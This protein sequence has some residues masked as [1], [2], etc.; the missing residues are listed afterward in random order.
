MEKPLLHT[1]TSTP[2]STTTTL[3]TAAP[4]NSTNATI[5]RPPGHVVV[6]SGGGGPV[7]KPAP[8][9]R[10][11]AKPSLFQPSRPFHSPWNF[12]PQFPR[13]MNRAVQQPAAAIAAHAEVLQQAV[14]PILV[15]VCYHV[16]TSF[17]THVR[18]LQFFV[19]LPMIGCIVKAWNH[20]NL[21]SSRRRMVSNN[22]F[23]RPIFR[24]IDWLIDWLFDWLMDW[25]ID[26][27]I[28]WM[29][30]WLID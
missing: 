20:G 19:F 23:F 3:T 1:A 11:L 2:T 18:L 30:D 9:V 13:R 26:W 22:K 27:L 28:D 5:P 10:P 8:P 21:S 15:C 17:C 29:I 25:L 6:T 16:L 7:F 24:S 14:L 4:L 12:R